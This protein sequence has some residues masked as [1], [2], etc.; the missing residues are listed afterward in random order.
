MSYN[1]S[2]T[3]AQLRASAVP[4]SL[5]ST[6]VT[7]TVTVTGA[8]TDTQIRASAL[9]VSLASTTITGTVAVT[10]AL[11]D[12]QLRA[13]AVPVSGTVTANAGS[14]TFAISAASLPLPTGAATAAKQPALGTAGTASADVITVQ[15]IASGTALPVSG[16]FFQ[17]TQPVSIAA[18]V[19]VS[20]PLTDAQ[21]RASV[22]PVSLTST[23]ITGTVATTQSGAWNITNI[24]GTVSLPTGAATDAILTGGTARTKLT[25]GTNNVG[26]TDGKTASSETL[27]DQLKVAAALRLL[28]TS[29]A[30]GAELVAA[31]GDQAS[32]LWV[33]VKET[34]ELANGTLEYTLTLILTELRVMNTMLQIGLSI[35]D[36]PESLRNS[37]LST[38][39]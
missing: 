9:P 29:Q 5:A 33:N 22:V 18:T 20:G 1:S 6:T 27:T 26:V 35:R 24:T 14:G 17:A 10:G 2:L 34:S 8:L 36:E 39:Q 23:T 4:V 37:I 32:G 7:G 25:D 13:T 3:D 31:K 38:V 16:A 30:D 12:T 11:T 28:D 19:A 21:L 15:G